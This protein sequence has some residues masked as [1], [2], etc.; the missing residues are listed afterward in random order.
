[1]CTDGGMIFLVFAIAALLSRLLISEQQAVAQP[2][3]CHSERQHAQPAHAGCV[4]KQE[5]FLQQL[6]GQE[7]EQAACD[8]PLNMFR[9]C[10]HG[11]CVYIALRV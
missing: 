2:L 4:G 5:L 8:H 10:A 1:M 11:A 6:L 7:P 3:Q 9:P